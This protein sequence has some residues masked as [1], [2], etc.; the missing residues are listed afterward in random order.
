MTK[1]E[2]YA[3]KNASP[4]GRAAAAKYHKSAKFKLVMR[5]YWFRV[6]KPRKALAKAS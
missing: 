4:A 6:L 1:K 5:R 2:R 3:R